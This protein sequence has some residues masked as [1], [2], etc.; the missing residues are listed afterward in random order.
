MSK[1]WSRTT[2]EKRK[3]FGALLD[4]A[5]QFFWGFRGG[6]P[7]LTRW[8]MYR[9]SVNEWEYISLCLL[10]AYFA[11][12][13]KGKAHG[14]CDPRVKR[15][16]SHFPLLAIYAILAKL[17]LSKKHDTKSLVSKCAFAETDE[18]A[19]KHHDE[20]FRKSEN[21]LRDVLVAPFGKKSRS[22]K[23]ENHRNEKF[24]LVGL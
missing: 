12:A 6:S 23:S 5:C 8:A 9:T 3:K 14:Q 1:K 11:L 19:K 24:V 13:S 20:K 10:Y 7:P 22:R 21:F 17:P 16:G 18:R 2:S 4:A 15:V